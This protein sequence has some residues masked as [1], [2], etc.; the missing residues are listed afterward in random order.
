MALSWKVTS[1]QR[2]WGA[3]FKRPL[4][5]AILVFLYPHPAPRLF[6]TFFCPSLR[7]ITLN[8]GGE[9]SSDQVAAPN[10]FVRLP[11]SQ[12][13]I[14]TDPEQELTP[15]DIENLFQ[16]AT[17]RLPRVISGSWE[18]DTSLY[19]LLFAL[20]GG[21]VAD[22][23]RI[24][25]LH[26][27]SGEICLA[28]MHARYSLHECGK[29]A[30]SA[31]FLLD[32][33]DHVQIPET[34]LRL[35][36]YYLEI[37]AEAGDLEE[38]LAA[39]AAGEPWKQDFAATGKVACMS[40][41]NPRYS[42][43]PVLAAPETIPVEA[44]WR[45]ERPENHIPL[46]FRCAATLDWHQ[47]ESVRL[48]LAQGLWGMRFDAFLVWHNAVS[49]KQLPP[50]WDRDAY[51][52]WPRAYG[53]DTWETGSGAILYADPRPPQDICR[54]AEHLA[55]LQLVLT[56]PTD[57]HAGRPRKQP[58]QFEVHLSGFSKEV[59]G[60]MDTTRPPLAKFW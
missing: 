23:R 30:S 25:E 38:L 5:D 14:E 35:A 58:W 2:S 32:Y 36:R 59:K 50:D 31:M 18:E 24:N 33:E 40:C 10:H 11:A 16:E 26:F 21:A 22:I 28:R 1:W 55:A 37:E 8:G 52:L 54:K 17:A 3:M 42:W 48:G 51:P 47:Q 19:R 4:G 20:L 27:R 6:H 34:A 44:T 9:M 43:R 29:V 49:T 53:G 45:Y 57:A 60:I 56:R 46:C 39:A 41:A 15:G 12:V 13:V 7:I